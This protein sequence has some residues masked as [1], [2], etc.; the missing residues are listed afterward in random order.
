VDALV[1]GRPGRGAAPLA[2]E[3]IRLAASV[4]VSGLETGGEQIART[5]PPAEAAARSREAC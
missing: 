1:S 5:G 4:A 3:D 2:E